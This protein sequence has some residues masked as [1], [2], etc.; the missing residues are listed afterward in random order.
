VPDTSDTSA[1]PLKQRSMLVILLA[2]C[3]TA[4][5]TFEAADNILDRQLLSDLR[6]MIERSEGELE[7]LNGLIASSA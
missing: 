4:R 3:N 5:T 7:K 6:G 2:A 1:N